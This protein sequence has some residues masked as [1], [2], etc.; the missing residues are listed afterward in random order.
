MILEEQ[1]YM[2]E[3]IERLEQAIS[4]RILLEPKTVSAKVMWALSGWELPMHK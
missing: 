3:D 4:D 1:R 2:H